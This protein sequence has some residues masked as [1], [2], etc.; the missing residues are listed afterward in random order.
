[1][2]PLV[3]GQLRL[4]ILKTKVIIGIPLWTAPFVLNSLTILTLPS[5]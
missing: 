5:C 3:G 2:Q 1:M 4:W